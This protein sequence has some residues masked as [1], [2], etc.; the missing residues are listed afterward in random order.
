MRF[1]WLLRLISILR[2]IASFICVAIG[3]A[4]GLL[5]L[6]LS[7]MWGS[8]GVASGAAIVLVGLYLSNRR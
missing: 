8:I 4:F 3:A 2:E 5:I 7:P 6:Y 1:A